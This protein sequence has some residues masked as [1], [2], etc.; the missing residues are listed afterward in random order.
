ML[1][2]VLAKVILPH[3]LVVKKVVCSTVF[4]HV[5]NMTKKTDF[6]QDNKG[7]RLV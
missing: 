2:I 5:T 4:I 3:Q 1:T 6:M 7:S